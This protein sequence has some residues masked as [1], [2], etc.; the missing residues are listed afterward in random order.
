MTCYRLD[1]LVQKSLWAKQAQSSG[2][3]SPRVANVHPCVAW[4]PAEDP[5]KRCSTA[6]L[7]RCAQLV[8]ISTHTL[9]GPDHW[10]NWVNKTPT[11]PCLWEKEIHAGCQSS[12]LDKPLLLLPFIV[13]HIFQQN[14]KWQRK[15]IRTSTLHNTA[16]WGYPWRSF[17]L[18]LC[19]HSCAAFQWKPGLQKRGGGMVHK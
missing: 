4:D 3:S 6:S 10:Q 13:L 11:S 1:F 19:L 16:T 8:L 9:H 18:S 17:W 14:P 15:V 5:L 2:L 12:S 7:S